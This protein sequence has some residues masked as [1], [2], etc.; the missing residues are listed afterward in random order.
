MLLIAFRKLT[1]KVDQIMPACKTS[2]NLQ[3]LLVPFQ[4]LLSMDEALWQ[5]HDDVSQPH[6]VPFQLSHVAENIK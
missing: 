3:T 4:L 5:V 1:S 6:E 2:N